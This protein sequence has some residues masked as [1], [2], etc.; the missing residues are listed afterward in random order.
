MSREI[1]AVGASQQSTSPFDVIRKFDPDGREYWSSRELAVALDYPDYSKFKPVIEKAIVSCSKSGGE[2]EIHFV[3]SSAMSTLGNNGK[4]EIDDIALSR[5]ACYLIAQNASPSK[6]IVS[7]AQVYFAIQTRRQ[8]IKDQEREDR[9]RLKLREELK[10]HNKLLLDTAKEAGVI[11]PRDYAIFQNYG[12]MG[13]Y[14]GLKSSDIREK[15]GLKM[16]EHIL[17]HMGS[18]ELA[19]NLFR[20]TQAEEKIRKERIVGKNNAN[21]AH[22]NVGKKVRD[23]I[24]NI[25][26]TMPEDLPP[27]ESIKKIPSKLKELNEH[28]DAKKK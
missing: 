9:L 16:N 21:R 11:D 12:Y 17:D 27:A 23:A 7:R 3:Q 19:A 28:T 15:K 25:G 10:G 24:D 22:Y 14:N 5:I 8:E 20:A 18:T 1:E 6:Q 2:V 4:R 26:G 13:L